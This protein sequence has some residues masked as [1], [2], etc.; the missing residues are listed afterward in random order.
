MRSRHAS[1]VAVA[2]LV[3]A[4][5]AAGCGSSSSAPAGW[6]W[7]VVPS[8]TTLPLN[9]VVAIDDTHAWAVGIGSS[10]V[11]YD[12]TRW[13]LHPQSG[14]IVPGGRLWGVCASGA[15]SVWAVGSDGLVLYFD[16]N[17]WSVLAYE[18]GSNHDL[19]SCSSPN[20]GY[21]V[22]SSYAGRSPC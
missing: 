4:V 10:L 11:F 18:S 5:A 21:A 16:G 17:S 20:P 1:L 14:T 22:A 3:T 8:P 19:W 9:S 6:D 7:S 13:T 12:G 2:V 15:A